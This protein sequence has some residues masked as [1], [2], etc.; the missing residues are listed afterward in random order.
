MTV[1]TLVFIIFAL[2]CLYQLAA[3]MLDVRI[4]RQMRD[5]RYRNQTQHTFGCARQQLMLLTANSEISD[6]SIT[7]M[8]FYLMNTKVMRHPDRYKELSQMMQSSLL[9]DSHDTNSQT[10]ELLEKESKSWTPKVKDMVH[11]NIEALNYLMVFNSPK[12]RLFLTIAKLIH[13]VWKLQK[14]KYYGFFVSSTKIFGFGNPE[15]QTFIKVKNEL[16]HL[17]GTT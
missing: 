10:A 16:E 12:L 4:I 13:K 7:F 15:T 17:A 3:I 8:F 9:G 11:Q 6:D 2:F 5:I 1:L 14:R